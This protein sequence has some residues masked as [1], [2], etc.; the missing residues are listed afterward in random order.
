MLA[1]RTELVVSNIM[2]MHM[3]AFYPHT[4]IYVYIISSV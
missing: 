3:L 1:V 2:K 4:C